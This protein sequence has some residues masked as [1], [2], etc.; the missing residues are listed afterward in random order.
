MATQKPCFSEL[1]DQYMRESGIMDSWMAWR[2]D[3]SRHTI[4]RWRQKNKKQAGTKKP[5]CEKL[6]QA[7]KLLH[8]TT[9]QTRE[10]LIAAHCQPAIPPI[11]PIG[12]PIQCAKEFFGRHEILERIKMAWTKTGGLENLAVIGPRASGKTSLLHYLEDLKTS[13]SEQETASSYILPKQLQFAIINF[14]D[15]GMCDPN[16]LMSEVLQQLKLTVPDTC[17]LASFSHILKTQLKIRTVIMMDEIGAGLKAPKLDKG[18]WH[19]M[20]Y[21]TGEIA[22]LGFLITATE[23]VEELAKNA[24]KPSPFFNLFAQ[25]LTLNALSQKESIEFID[26]F[27]LNISSSDK[28]W[29]LETTLGWPVLLQIACEEYL[30][31][32]EKEQI[33]DVWKT[34]S[35]KR[36][37]S[38]GLENLK[39]LV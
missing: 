33:N 25:S 8:L 14:H 37:N 1:F 29:I 3:V 13:G 20:R 6:Q 10:L 7:A 15:P 22:H 18:F 38:N 36:I 21:F 35:L 23:P 11:P 34:K 5:N 19:S 2:L 12:K 16:I 9:Q 32:Q 39:S 24:D 31:A 17:D 28:T 27:I 30:Q 4:M 26:H